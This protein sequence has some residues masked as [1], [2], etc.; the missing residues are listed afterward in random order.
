LEP[1]G[2]VAQRRDRAR[3]RQIEKDSVGAGNALFVK[4]DLR[5]ELD[6]DADDVGKHG[7]LNASNRRGWT[8]AGH[9]GGGR[10]PA[11]LG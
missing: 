3:R 5:I 7:A 4:L 2:L 10:R 8:G 11:S 1:D 6:D 9:F